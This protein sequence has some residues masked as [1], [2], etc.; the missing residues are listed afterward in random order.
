M[1]QS[2]VD[3]PSR[4]RDCLIANRQRRDRPRPTMRIVPGPSHIPDHPRTV[5]EHRTFSVQN[6]SQ[7]MVGHTE[8]TIIIVEWLHFYYYLGTYCLVLTTTVPA[9]PPGTTTICIV[10]ILVPTSPWLSSC[11]YRSQYG[12]LCP[13]SSCLLIPACLGYR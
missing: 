3:K 11:V 10:F 12:I 13:I 4:I 5:P 2:Q 6:V 1:G 7:I 8:G 9:F